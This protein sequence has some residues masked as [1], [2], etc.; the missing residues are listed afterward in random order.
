MREIEFLTSFSKEN[1][2]V[3]PT[4]HK[5]KF[6]KC[7]Q[8]KEMIKSIAP[9]ISSGNDQIP[10]L[11]IRKFPISYILVLVTIFN[12]CLTN[13]Y[14]PKAWKTAVIIPL[15]K[16]NGVIGVKDFR[17][18]SLTSNLGKLYENLLLNNIHA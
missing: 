9:K 15:P 3:Y 14:F 1:S 5:D 2:A 17:P 16:K 12:H 10:N 8:V 4:T 18:I 7:S 6:T 11:V 13:A